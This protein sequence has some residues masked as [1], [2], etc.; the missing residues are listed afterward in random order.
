[1]SDHITIRKAAGK[2]VVRAGGAVI[3]ESDQALE[4]IEGSYPPVIYF[5]R[6]DIGMAF[7]EKTSKTTTCP[8]KGAATYYTVT[9]PDEELTDAA[10]SYEAPIKAVAGIKDHIAF[11]TDRI[12]VEQL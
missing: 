1:M 9:S 3:G 6:G 11:Y 8:H 5:P 12:T 2:W 10:W 7:L 4:L